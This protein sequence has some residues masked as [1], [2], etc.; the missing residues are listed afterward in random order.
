MSGGM[1]GGDV[2]GKGS[3][4]G[5]GMHGVG[6]MHCKGVCV[7]GGVHGIRSMNR[8]YTSYWNAFLLLIDSLFI[9]HETILLPDK[10]I[11]SLPV[12]VGITCVICHMSKSEL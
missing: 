6:G 5:R 4:H 2:H 12:Y 1:H 10:F 7:A 3:V 9:T 8:Q 11:F